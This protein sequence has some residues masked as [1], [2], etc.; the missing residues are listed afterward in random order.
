MG[1]RDDDEMD[2]IN[3]EFNSLVAGLNLDQSSP[4]SYLDELDELEEI[5]SAEKAEIYNPPIVR[6]GIRGSLSHF[7]LTLRRWW[8]RPNSDESDGAVI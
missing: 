5:E 1:P 2:L 3:A 8:Q 6:R 4:R 7:L